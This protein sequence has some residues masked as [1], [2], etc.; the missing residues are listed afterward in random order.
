MVGRVA[1][2]VLLGIVGDSA[3][4]KTTLT[5]GLVR[6]L[7]EQQVSHVSADHYHRFDRRQRAQRGLTPLH[8]DC[9]HLD[10]LQQHLEHLRAGEPVLKPVYRHRDGS[11]GPPEYLV[12][13]HFVIVEGLLGLHAPA[14]RDLYDV[15]VFL[16]PPE[17]LRRRWK[18]LRDCSRRG[19]TTDEV[20]EELDRREADA[21][22]FIYPQRRRAEIVISFAPGDCGDPERLDTSI[23]VRPGS[24]QLSLTALAGA[25]GDAVSIQDQRGET[26]LRIAGT[27]DPDRSAR[28]EEALWELMHF[29]EHL[30]TERLGEFTVGTELHRS[31]PLAIVQLLVLYQLVAADAAAAT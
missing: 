16:D 10:I 18:V 8:P 20:L 28:L 2:P 22:A 6:I 27:I 29:A 25:A 3:S 11:F 30:R 1:R 24:A 7:G 14:M 31:D 9:N 12:P 15:R 19:Y 21:E 4:G 13:R 26:T 5:R 23:T 17:E